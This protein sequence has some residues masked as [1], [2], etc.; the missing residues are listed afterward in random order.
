MSRQNSCEAGSEMQENRE[1]R[2]LGEHGVIKDM[3]FTTRVY[4]EDPREQI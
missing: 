3:K 4:C 2:P 1:L